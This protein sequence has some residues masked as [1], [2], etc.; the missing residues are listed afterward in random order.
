MKTIF[1]SSTFRDFQQE[2]DILHDKVLP[3][4]NALGRKYG[5]EVSFCDL[6]WGVD[7]SNEADEE[8]SS[9]KVLSVCMN[10]IDRSRPYMLV[11][12]GERYGFMP[13]KAAIDKEAKRKDMELEQLEISVTALEVEYGAL[14]DKE[15]LANTWFYFREL[16]SEEELPPEFLAESREHEQKLNALKDRIRQL[17]GDR[18]RF[19]QASWKD[20]AVTGLEAFAEQIEKDVKEQLRSEW[21]AYEKLDPYER[22]S[23]SQWNYMNEKSRSF[24]VFSDF[25]EEIAARL[26]GPEPA[27]LVEGRAGSGKST[28]FAKVC[29]DMKQ[30]GVPVFP[31]VCGSTSL[32]TDA[33]SIMK[34]LVWQLETFLDMD[35]MEE[36]QKSQQA[37]LHLP[38]MEEWREH[39]DDLCLK[40]ASIQPILIA[41]DALDQL[42]AG[43]MR[44][45]LLFLPSVRMNGIH[46]FLTCLDDFKT[47]G[48][49]TRVPMPVMTEKERRQVVKGIL[50]SIGK[51]LSAPVV[52]ALIQKEHGDTPLYLYLTVS[53]LT[54]MNASDFQNIRERGDGIEGI[55]AHQLDMVEEMPDELE[56]MCVTLIEAVGERVNPQMTRT[57]VDYLALSRLGF[58]LTDLEGLLKAE[59]IRFHP[60]EFAQFVNY[61]NELF[62]LRS[63]GRYDFMHKSLRQGLLKRMKDEG[64]DEICGHERIVA[65]LETLPED[66]M[67]RI[68]EMT[69]E[70]IQADDIGTFI[71]WLTCIWTSNQEVQ[72]AAAR[73]VAQQCREDEG[74][75]LSENLET[76]WKLNYKSEED[77]YQAVLM[78]AYFLTAEVCKSFGD[79][80]WENRSKIRIATASVSNMERLVQ[81]KPTLTNRESLSQCLSLLASYCMHSDQISDQQNAIELLKKAHKIRLEMLEEQPD[82]EASHKL[83]LSQINGL[84]SMAYFIQRS[85]EN[86]KKARTY[87]EIALQYQEEAKGNV[88]DFAELQMRANAHMRIAESCIELGDLESL[89]MAASHLLKCE[90]ELNK[91]SEESTVGQACLYTLGCIYPALA[92]VYISMNEIEKE[93]LYEEGLTYAYRALD[94][95]QKLE[96]HKSTPQT[97][98]ALASAWNVLGGCHISSGEEEHLKEAIHCLTE[99]LKIHQALAAELGTPVTKY[100]VANA[101]SML[102]KVYRSLDSEEYRKKALEC[103][104]EGEKIAEILVKEMPSFSHK[105][106]WLALLNKAEMSA[107]RYGDYLRQENKDPEETL[108]YYEKALRYSQKWVAR[109]ENDKDK[110]ISK[111]ELSLNFHRLGRFYRENGNNIE[112]FDKAYAYYQE[113]A[114][115]A[116]E[117]NDETI[118][119]KRE[120]RNSFYWLGDLAEAYGDRSHLYEAIHCFEEY[121]RWSLN[122]E[123]LT[124]E[125]KDKNETEKSRCRLFT[126]CQSLDVLLRDN[127][128]NNIFS[129]RLQLQTKSIAFYLEI[130][131]IKRT[132]RQWE[133]IG[134]G[135]HNIGCIYMQLDGSENLSLSLK[136]LHMAAE[137]MEH[138]QEKVK[139]HYENLQ[140]TC[141]HALSV[142]YDLLEESEDSSEKIYFE[143]I[144]IHC[145]KNLLNFCETREYLE[146]LNKWSY[147]LGTLYD[148]IEGKDAA[149]EAIHCYKLEVWSY[150]R[151]IALAS[152]SEIQKDLEEE[153]CAAYYR[154]ADRLEYLGKE[155]YLDKEGSLREA[156]FYEEK[157]VALSRKSVTDTPDPDMIKDLTLSLMQLGRLY[158]KLGDKDAQEKAILCYEETLS[159]QMQILHAVSPLN[160]EHKNQIVGN[161]EAKK[162]AI[163]MQEKIIRIRE[164]ILKEEPTEKHQKELETAKEKLKLL[165]E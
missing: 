145:L 111:Y 116:M 161:A 54:L 108:K 149:C 159:L 16:S 25:S 3:A 84:L 4:I 153:L 126:A 28:L 69:W 141:L 64:R 12:L 47:P 107:R 143:K 97:Q 118:E 49:V 104:E 32:T 101:Y 123:L 148:E 147:E 67:I 23:L 112:D 99:S 36:Q 137:S 162:T 113:Y 63:D 38:A 136:W 51:E 8:E 114:K 58:R 156:I 164:E 139:E 72:D 105:E 76:L 7:T 127:L 77:K 154:V 22:D 157:D 160:T 18:I 11:L 106:L 62:L 34:S 93:N 142:I 82:K 55:T 71:Y 19:Y 43:E 134:A 129:E 39:L 37:D 27:I 46:L 91:L 13:G 138:I 52:D 165:K 115:L 30:K 96:R 124:G 122:V 83:R 98:T 89:H 74:K 155:E 41:V 60:L 94:I 128:Q 110:R 121:Y 6:R 132:D 119:A 9:A 33:F 133:L 57:A 80:L 45:F 44:D 68:Q 40:A 88:D 86:L 42:Q 15:T 26:G 87:G 31:F 1:V 109:E 158:T 79:S 78:S 21:E 95:M 150:E 24:T 85:D 20:G 53:R 73:D 120:V 2:R 59:G 92:K 70:S 130:P 17:A 125:E 163:S 61:M 144:Y 152:N 14:L 103:A 66:D 140:V 117:L 131:E 151:L 90:S 65:Y 135:S 48:N 10:E 102:H 81:Q 56:D 100:N 75:W 29:H 5:E 50:K 146:E 35:H